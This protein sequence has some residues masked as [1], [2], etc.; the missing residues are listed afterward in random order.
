MRRTHPGR[1]QEGW[2]ELTALS[3]ADG[4]D[5]QLIEVFS[6]AFDL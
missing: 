5:E 6:Q 3:A 2:Y 1:K 4:V